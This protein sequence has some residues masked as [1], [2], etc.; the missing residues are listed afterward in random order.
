MFG[1]CF[2]LRKTTRQQLVPYFERSDAF[3]YTS[4]RAQGLAAEA[5]RQLDGLPNTTAK[6]IL[7]D[8]ADFAV[9]RTF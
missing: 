9:Q 6:R 1:G 4:K 5:R 3:E 7:S 8:I 2:P